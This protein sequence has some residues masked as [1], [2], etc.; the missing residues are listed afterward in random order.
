[1]LGYYWFESTS[2]CYMVSTNHTTFESAHQ[3]CKSDK[4]DL[5]SVHSD[6]ENILLNGLIM[7]RLEDENVL[8]EE[9]K[10][11]IGLKTQNKEYIWTDGSPIDFHDWWPRTPDYTRSKDW[12]LVSAHFLEKEY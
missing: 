11:W 5:V 12:V 4:G 1:M 10:F 8:E 3:H 9:E 6:L 2:S 7:K